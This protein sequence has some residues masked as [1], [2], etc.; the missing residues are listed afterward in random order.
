MNNP[1][2]AMPDLCEN[3]YNRLEDFFKRIDIKTSSYELKSN[4]K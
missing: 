3:M 2:S 4:G 1:K